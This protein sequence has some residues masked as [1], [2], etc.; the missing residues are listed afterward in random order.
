MVE[1]VKQTTTPESQD[2]NTGSITIPGSDDSTSTK[3]YIFIP[4]VDNTYPKIQQFGTRFRKKI[5]DTGC[6]IYNTES[7]KNYK[8]V[9][10][11]QDG[12]KCFEKKITCLEPFTEVTEEV[13]FSYDTCP[14][15]DPPQCTTQVCTEE[16]DCFVY[17]ESGEK[18]TFEVGFK[19]KGD[20]KN[21]GDICT[22]EEED[23]IA[24]TSQTPEELCERLLEECKAV[25]CKVTVF[26]KKGCEEIN[27]NVEECGKYKNCGCES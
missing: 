16:Y 15:D 21:Y 9:E 18:C 14:L 13:G 11:F 12:N 4:K 10:Y 2:A 5:Q 17:S 25:S 27:I 20:G 6:I 8:P 19:L 23:E 3:T 26:N 7:N 22:E 1:I 24:M